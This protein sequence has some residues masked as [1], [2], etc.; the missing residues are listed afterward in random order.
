MHERINRDT[1]TGKDTDDHTRAG[2]AVSKTKKDT[3]VLG[4]TA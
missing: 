3:C 2:P 1:V 4:R